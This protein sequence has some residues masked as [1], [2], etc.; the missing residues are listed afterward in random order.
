MLALITICYTQTSTAAVTL[1]SSS[2]PRHSASGLSPAPASLDTTPLHLLEE[3][4]GKEH[5]Q[6]HQ[7]LNKLRGSLP[8]ADTL[9][10]PMLAPGH[11]LLLA[12]FGHTLIYVCVCVCVCV[13]HFKWV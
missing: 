4:G 6:Q 11:L 1:K 13:V 2:P 9:L 5:Y 3:R 8:E 12:S 10:P 7:H